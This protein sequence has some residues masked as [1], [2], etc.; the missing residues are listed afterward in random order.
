M[1]DTE[2][3]AMRQAYEAANRSRGDLYVEILR[4]LEKRLG[5][6]EAAAAMKEAIHA[7]GRSL[8]GAIACHAPKSFEGVLHDF[9]LAPD[10]GTTFGAR[11]ERCD[12]EGLDV[13]FMNCPLKNAWTDAGLPDEE[14]ARLCAIA[15]EADHG[16]MAAAGFAVAIETWQ[17][18]RTGCCLLHIRER[19]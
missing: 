12:G 10:G 19:T 6:E 1:N 2:S 11:V 4:S 17:P 16:T 18:G 7:W 15:A 5:R 13:Q 9:A 3:D 8:G 14:V